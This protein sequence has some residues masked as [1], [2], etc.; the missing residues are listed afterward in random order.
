MKRTVQYGGDKWFSPKYE[1]D[2]IIS[3]Y[4][5]GIDDDGNVIFH[6]NIECASDIKDLTDYSLKARI[7]RKIYSIYVKI[8]WRIR[9]WRNTE[10]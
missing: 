1:F 3:K 10:S 5:Q 2:G 9:T 8:A 4:E 7:Y 6:T